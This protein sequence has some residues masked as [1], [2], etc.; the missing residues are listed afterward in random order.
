[1]FPWLMTVVPAIAIALAGCG[2]APQQALAG[3]V[4]VD[5]PWSRE[6]PA[7]APVAGGFLTI[8]NRGS[9]DD[10]LVTVR[11]DAAERVEIHETRREGDMVRMRALP[12]G[13]PLPAGDTVELRPG[14]YHLMFI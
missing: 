5:L 11:T 12:D 4:E 3:T 1:K 7:E 8:H 9:A 6:V 2:Q 13:L 10:R 14:G